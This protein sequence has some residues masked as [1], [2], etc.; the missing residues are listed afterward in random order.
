MF[1]IIR[2]YMEHGNST[3][4][5]HSSYSPDCKLEKIEQKHKEI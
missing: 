3:D 2:L 4:T 5:H 1:L